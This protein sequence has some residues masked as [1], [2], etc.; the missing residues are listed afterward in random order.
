MPLRGENDED[1]FTVAEAA[2]LWGIQPSTVRT[3]ISGDTPRVRVV[4]LNERTPLIPRSEID[5]YQRESRG[6][7]GR[8]KQQ[9]SE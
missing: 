3:L 1:L 6:K 5:R 2:D 8:K 7:P 9:Q 4:R